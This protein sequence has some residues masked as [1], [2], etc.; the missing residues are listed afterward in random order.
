MRT[1]LTVTVAVRSGFRKLTA[2]VI[3]GIVALIFVLFPVV[4]RLN[5]VEL[6]KLLDSLSRVLIWL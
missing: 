4:V 2:P 1:I 3:W 6:G 5:S